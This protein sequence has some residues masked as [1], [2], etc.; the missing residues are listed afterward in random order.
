MENKEQ[1][2]IQKKGVGKSKGAVLK[3]ISP[4]TARSI[5]Q[6]KEK[7]NKKSFGRKV[8]DGEIIGLAVKQLSEI[9]FTELQEATYSAKDKLHMAHEEFMKQHGKMSLDE[10]IGKLMR[11]EVQSV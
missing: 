7:V 8:K 3:K 11:G 9:H 6:I 1:T 10:F 5:L 2:K 4:E